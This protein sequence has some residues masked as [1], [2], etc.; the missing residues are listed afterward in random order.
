MHPDAP[1]ASRDRQG[2]QGYGRVVAA[3]E[4]PWLAVRAS[5]QLAQESLPGGGH[6][7]RERVSVARL[8]CDAIEVSQQLPVVLG[9]LGEAQARIQNHLFRAHSG[10]RNGRQPAAELAVHLR[11]DVGVHRGSVH[12]R[13]VP[14]PV[15]HNVRHSGSGDDPSHIRIRQAAAHVVD[16]LGARRQGLPGHFSP[17]GVDAD[18][19]ASADQP[20]DDRQHATQLVIHWYA[21]GAWPS[22]F[23]AHVNDVAALAG[24]L[25]PVRDRL[26]RV[27]PGSAVGERIRRD[28]DDAHHQAAL[29]SWQPGQAPARLV[30]SVVPVGVA[31]HACQSTGPHRDTGRAQRR[32][33]LA[34]GRAPLEHALQPTPELS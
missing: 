28:V 1:G 2:C 32:E 23:A 19:D 22:R 27:Q 8:P 4:R 3:G 6:Q 24:K 10:G 31:G 20:L 17:H 30:S 14:A 12:V 26:V 9:Q 11:H 25:K 7:H 13:T 5:Q 16:H 18:V 34:D 15:H 29:L 33:P 21:Q